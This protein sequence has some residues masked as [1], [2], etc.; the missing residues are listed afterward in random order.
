MASRWW[1]TLVVGVATGVDLLLRFGGAFD[2]HRVM[3]GEAVLFSLTA[4]GLTLLLLREPRARGW[5]HGIRV[6]IVWFFAL[7][8]LRP[9][10]W[11][12]GLALETANIGTVVGAVSGLVLW[13]YRR[14]RRG[15]AAH[16]R[17]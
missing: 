7:G 11:L 6:A 16:G 2:F 5:R 1:W 15:V 10:L 17:P 14:R 8:A 4:I 13:R 12:S 3:V 9:V